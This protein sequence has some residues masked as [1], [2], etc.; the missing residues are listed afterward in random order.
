MSHLKKNDT[1]LVLSG[2]DR[3]KKGRV[4]Q[5]NPTDERVLV[6][7]VNFVKRHLKKGHPEAKEGGV[8]QKEASL[9]ISNLMVVCG[10]CHEASRIG[11]KQ[12][13]NG[14]RGRICKSCGEFIEKS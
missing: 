7:G 2:D 14:K 13:A 5:V 9:H 1:V 3:G 4:L 8:V 12:L 11:Y 6:E 10:V